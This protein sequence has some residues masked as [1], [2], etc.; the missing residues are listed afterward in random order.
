[1]VVSA[2]V[3]TVLLVIFHLAC[4]AV[5]SEMRRDGLLGSFG[6]NAMAAD[7]LHDLNSFFLSA[8][9]VQWAYRW[10]RPAAAPSLRRY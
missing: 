10:A 9:V 6:R 5:G 4:E 1:M 8:D 3:A 7:A 2:G